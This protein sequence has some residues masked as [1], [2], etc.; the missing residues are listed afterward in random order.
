MWVP[1]STK[2]RHLYEEYLTNRDFLR[3]MARSTLPVE[4]INYLKT[5]CRHPFL[6]EASKAALRRKE[7][8][9]NDS[10]AGKEKSRFNTS[11]YQESSIYDEPIPEVKNQPHSSKYRLPAND[12]GL[13]EL[14]ESFKSLKIKKKNKENLAGNSFFPGV[15]A[16]EGLL[17]DQQCNDSDDDENNGSRHFGQ[18]RTDKFR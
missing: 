6:L 3:A 2:Q 8:K 15:D 18:S 1:L 14:T 5:L 7:A 12:L 17:T 11:A 10:F 13:D 16:G 4:C 9:A